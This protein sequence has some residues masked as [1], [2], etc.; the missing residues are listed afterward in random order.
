MKPS[1]PCYHA[2]ATTIDNIDAHALE[3]NSDAIALAVLAYSYSTE[4]VNGVV[5]KSMPGRAEPAR[6]GRPA[7]ERSPR[8]D[9]GL[10]HHH[11][12]TAH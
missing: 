12:L 3:I 1:I 7:R 2:A 10:S 6:P 5:G 9:G 8:S 4:L 11:A